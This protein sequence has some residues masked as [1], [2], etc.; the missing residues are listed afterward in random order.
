LA[1]DEDL[2]CNPDDSSLDC[3][4]AKM[5]LEQCEKLGTEDC[6]EEK[7]ILIAEIKKTEPI[8]EIV[9]NNV[10]SSP[11]PKNDSTETAGPSGSAGTGPTAMMPVPAISKK[12][13]KKE[14]KV[15]DEDKDEDE[16]KK[17]KRKKRVSPDRKLIAE[18]SPS[19]PV[20]P[21]AEPIPIVAEAEP[22]PAAELATVTLSDVYVDTP[23][24]EEIKKIQELGIMK[25]SPDP[26]NPEKRTF[27][28]GGLMNRAEL[29]T[30]LTRWLF[31][32]EIAGSFER[33]KKNKKTVC[34][35]PDLKPGEWYADNVALACEKGLVKGYPDKT[36]KPEKEINAVEALKVIMES[37]S[38]FAPKIVGPVL[39]TELLVAG[40]KK[41]QWF[42]PYIRTAEKLNILAGNE[43]EFVKNTPSAPATRGWVAYTIA[44][45][46]QHS[47]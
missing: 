45:L 38:K 22:H 37:A 14:S 13:E 36:Y 40:K 11:A 29:A 1:F 20:L 46:F 42:V 23:H 47:L 17:P 30:V 6:A 26:E 19:E 18:T 5:E 8:L 21:Q 32:K 43:L 41:E 24:V 39:K 27:K 31:E 44:Q 9:Q 7:K 3:E 12:E 25:G 33:L 10:T 2:E 34:L 28:P 16:E 35:F 4:Q 15:L